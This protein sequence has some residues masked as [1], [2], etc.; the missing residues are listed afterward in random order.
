MES[1]DLMDVVLK[2][3]SNSMNFYLVF[4]NFLCRKDHKCSNRKAS[5]GREFEWQLQEKTKKQ[6]LFKKHHTEFEWEQIYCAKI[7]T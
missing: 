6:I 1:N 2:E 5:D 3:V 4:E 7:L